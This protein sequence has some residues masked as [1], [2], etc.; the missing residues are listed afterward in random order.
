MNILLKENMR[1][2]DNIMLFINF[3]KWTGSYGTVF[4]QERFFYKGKWT[5]FV[6]LSFRYMNLG[7]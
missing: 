5:P 1:K 4:K 7:Y 3:G 6:R 2:E